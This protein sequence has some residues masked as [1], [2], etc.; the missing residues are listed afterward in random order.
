MDAAKAEL[1]D[2]AEKQLAAEQIRKTRT[3][4]RKEL[5]NGKG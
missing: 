4:M 2:K 1:L 3:R 5:K